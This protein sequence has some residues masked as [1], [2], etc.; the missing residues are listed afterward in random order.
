MGR[1]LVYFILA[2]MVLGPVT[3]GQAADLAHRWSF[4]GDLEDS[5]G[6]QDAVI[7]DDGSNDGI[8]SDP[9]VTLTGGG[10]GSSDYIDLADGIVSSLGDVVTVELW[11]T[12]ISVQNWSRIFDFGTSTAH[13][14][15][16]SWTQGTGLNS[17]RVEWLVDGQFAASS[18]NGRYL[19]PL[20]R[21]KHTV[22]AAVYR[23]GKF[24]HRT[25]EV[26]YLVK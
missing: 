24:L 5:V 17:D 22:Q 13:N 18:R 1:Q 26:R 16:M 14:V 3:S 8:L 7:V 23:P 15:F 6:G 9:E 2:L 4:N 11:A 21:G 10:K 19:W 25:P 12:Q 20:Q